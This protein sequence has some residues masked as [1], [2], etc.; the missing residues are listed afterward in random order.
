MGCLK[1]FF[2]TVTIVARVPETFIYLFYTNIKG[3]I[4]SAKYTKLT[5]TQDLNCTHYIFS[6][7]TH[8]FFFLIKK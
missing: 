6:M 1:T 2:F 7:G 4:T 5:L 8:H 3:V